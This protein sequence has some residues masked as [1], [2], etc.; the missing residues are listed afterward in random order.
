MTRS[1]SENQFSY[2]RAVKINRKD[3][4]KNLLKYIDIFV[5]RPLAAL[6]VRAVYHTRITPNQITCFSGFIGLTAA[7][8]FYL[9]K[10]EYF[11][12]GGILAQ[13]SSIIDG[14]DGMLARAK[15]LGST[16]GA[17]LDLFFDRIVDVSTAIGIG[18]GA[19]KYYND[20]EYAYL[21]LLCGTLLLFQINTFYLNRTLQKKEKTGETGEMRAV[22]IWGICLFSI[23]NRLDLLIYTALVFTVVVNIVHAFHFFRLGWKEKTDQSETGQH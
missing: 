22:Q 10:P 19:A 16:Y 4:G 17:M 7:F 11:L 14:A 6:I 13:L 9:G 5:N 21:G 15:N 18:I 1:D 8:L 23:F 2:A 12:M 20:P 3:A